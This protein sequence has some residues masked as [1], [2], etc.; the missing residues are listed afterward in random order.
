VQWEDQSGNGGVVF[1]H[2][3]CVQDPDFSD[4]GVPAR[5]K[6]PIRFE[7]PGSYHLEMRALSSIECAGDD[8]TKSS[9]TLEKEVVVSEAFSS[10]GDPD[11][12]TGP[13]DVSMIEQ[14]QESS[15][16]SAT[17]EI[18]HRIRTFDTWTDEQLGGPARMELWFDLDGDTEAFER[19][20]IVDLDERDATV[21]ASM[22]NWKTGRAQG[23]AAVFRPDDR[24]LELRF[25][26]A[27]LGKRIRDY[28]WFA[29]TDG[30]EAQGCALEEPCIDRAPDATTMKHRL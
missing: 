25:P 24:T 13:F 14:T 16:T 9:K 18:V 4:P 15:E 29:L 23:Y 21:R 22:I 11:D 12:S 6:I 1:A 5:L 2:T 19:V 30:G 26:P 8:T 20:L 28:G 27:L 3:F 10:T 7:Q 17:T